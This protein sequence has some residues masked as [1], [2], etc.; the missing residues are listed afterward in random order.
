[1]LSSLNAQ[2]ATLLPSKVIP[3]AKMYPLGRLPVTFWYRDT[4]Y[5]DDL[6][7]HPEIQ[8]TI[9][10]WKACKGCL[11]ITPTLAVQEITSPP[12]LGRSK[13]SL[14]SKKQLMYPTVFDGQI[15]SMEGEQFHISFTDDVNPLLSN[16]Y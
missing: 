4:K 9:L 8:G 3:G 2:V 15:R 5:W 10:S 7:I 13:H 12:P 16:F 6:C 14:H 11:L 1:M